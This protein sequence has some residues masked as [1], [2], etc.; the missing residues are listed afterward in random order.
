MAAFYRVTFETAN[1]EDLRQAFALTDDSGAPLDLTGAQLRM[2]IDPVPGPDTGP[3][4]I[5]ASLGNG[6]I[7]LA[8]ATAGQFTI[9][10]PAAVMRTVSPGSYR[11]DLVVTLASGETH[12]V[13]A[14]ALTLQAGVTP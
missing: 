5:E 10:I 12:R 2:G 3:P 8:S 9:A 11:H 1:N 14:G 6:R 7:V 4:V 13:W